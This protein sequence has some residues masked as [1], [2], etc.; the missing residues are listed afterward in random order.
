MTGNEPLFNRVT[1]AGKALHDGPVV[2]ATLLQRAL[3]IYKQNGAVTW[4]A[5]FA[6]AF[7]EGQLYHAKQLV[8]QRSKRLTQARGMEE[9]QSEGTNDRRS[10]TLELSSL[11]YEFVLRKVLALCRNEEVGHGRILLKFTGAKAEECNGEPMEIERK[12]PQKE[13]GLSSCSTPK[14][15]G[16]VDAEVKRKADRSRKVNQGAATS[17]QEKTRIH[18]KSASRFVSSALVAIVDPNLTLCSVEL[19]S[20]SPEHVLSS[21]AEDTPLDG[22]NGKSQDKTG[23]LLPLPE[24]KHVLRVELTLDQL[25][26]NKGKVDLL[27]WLLLHGRAFDIDSECK[28]LFTRAVGWLTAD[29]QG[30]LLGKP[31]SKGL[32][33]QDDWEGL[34][35]VTEVVVDYAATSSE[36]V[37][38]DLCQLCSFLMRRLV[39][40]GTMLLQREALSSNSDQG[41]LC[42]RTYWLMQ[43]FADTFNVRSN[44]TR[45]VSLLHQCR[46]AFAKTSQHAISLPHC[47][48]GNY[49][50]AETL[51]ERIGGVQAKATL[52]SLRSALSKEAN[53]PES[54]SRVLRELEERYVSQSD[55][56]WCLSETWKEFAGFPSTDAS[57]ELDWLKQ[58]ENASP[59]VAFHILSLNNGKH[60]SFVVLAFLVLQALCKRCLTTEDG[61]K[62]LTLF[63]QVSTRVSH[64]LGK[65]QMDLN[66]SFGKLLDAEQFIETGFE[67]ASVLG[68]QD[69]T[70]CLEAVGVIALYFNQ[71]S[72]FQRRA[73][74]NLSVNVTKLD[75]ALDAKY[76]KARSGLATDVLKYS[77][78]VSAVLHVWVQFCESTRTNQT[79][80]GD[81]TLNTLLNP[82][83]RLVYMI[84]YAISKNAGK[85]PTWTKGLCGNAMVVAAWL[86]LVYE[87]RQYKTYGKLICTLRVALESQ[88]SRRE[89]IEKLARLTTAELSK[90]EVVLWVNQQEDRELSEDLETFRQEAMNQSYYCLY[91]LQDAAGG[92]R[93]WEYLS[94]TCDPT[95]PKTKDGVNAYFTY[96]LPYLEGVTA[97]SS[98]F[99]HHEYMIEL[100]RNSLDVIKDERVQ[101]PFSRSVEEQGDI[102]EIFDVDEKFFTAIETSRVQLDAQHAATTS[103]AET[104]SRIHFILAEAMSQIRTVKPKSRKRGA[105]E[106]DDTAVTNHEPLIKLYQADLT[107]NPWRIHSWF[108]YGLLVRD[109]ML[110][111]QTAPRFIARIIANWFSSDND[112]ALSSSIQE[113]G[114]LYRRL[115]LCLRAWFIVTHLVKQDAKGSTSEESLNELRQRHILPLFTRVFCSIRA[116]QETDVPAKATVTRVNDDG[117]YDLVGYFDCPNHFPNPKD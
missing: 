74:L 109:Q 34:L 99:E 89:S 23:S 2:Q 63:V 16:N 31:E 38:K 55:G 51:N 97:Y 41:S 96:L 58:Q 45:T 79:P 87:C 35:F 27:E 71:A 54:L 65:A 67:V 47:S 25:E 29:T 50:D 91:G 52:D 43:K 3:Q 18:N 106:N 30:R 13:N 6:S 76:I 28:K 115:K 53:D 59:L 84:N 70:R 9:L 61:E 103:S 4:P 68:D 8:L 90:R 11:K 5:R 113:C 17:A 21:L 33:R 22:L 37:R 72:F 105:S 107:F 98:G 12:M 81:L 108:Q 36:K 46:D 26:R 60:D 56:I 86:V 73:A 1:T 44:N 93:L 111:D 78:F 40:F 14:Q 100:L 82:L 7:P 32:V 92:C 117:T 15:D 80:L 104:L 42:V 110:S 114:A 88:C 49:I 102:L 116:Y 66:P 57:V 112:S 39:I 85:E 19:L 10:V 94:I 48:Q 101:G 24:S 83:L 75:Y 20:R 77:Q 69:S 64:T 95:Y 62:Y